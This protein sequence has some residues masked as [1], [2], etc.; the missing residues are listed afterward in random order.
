[1]EIGDTQIKP[2]PAW[3]ANQPSI[4]QVHPNASALFTG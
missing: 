3:G 1:L 2:R 4:R